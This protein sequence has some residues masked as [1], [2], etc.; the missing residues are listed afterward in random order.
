M[1]VAVEPMLLY[2]DVHVNG[3]TDSRYSIVFHTRLYDTISSVLK[4][5]MIYVR[6]RLGDLY[7]C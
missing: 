4:R 1:F 6:S 5:Y 2:F 7:L 3:Y